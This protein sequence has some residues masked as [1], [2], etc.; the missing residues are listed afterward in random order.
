[1]KTI[2]FSILV[3]NI[4]FS[5]SL[6]AGTGREDYLKDY[7]KKFYTNL[8]ENKPELSY[9]LLADTMKSLMKPEQF[10]SFWG[11]MTAQVG[12]FE[13]F[14]EIDIKPVDDNHL[15][16]INLFFERYELTGRISVN[17]NDKVVG[18]FITPGKSRAE[19]KVPDYSVADNFTEEDIKFGIDGYELDG[20]ITIP[21]NVKNYPVVIL[22]HG[23]GPND[24]DETIGGTKPFRDIAYGLSSNGVA[25]IR[26]NKR[27]KQHP[28]KIAEEIKT[29]GLDA[30]VV[31]DAVEAAK[32]ARVNAQK[33]GINK[34]KIFV[35]GHSLGASM[36][37]KVALRD[38]KI[39][40]IIIMAGYTRK[41]EQLLLDQYEYIFTLDDS[42]SADEMAEISKLK[43]QTLNFLSPDLSADTDPTTLPMGMNGYYARDIRDYNPS[44]TVKKVSCPIFVLQGERDY[45]VKLKDFNGWKKV[46]DGNKKATLKLYPKLN[47]LF[48][49][50]E[51][52]SIPS[53]YSEQNNVAKVIID[54]LNNWILKN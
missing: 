21:K 28:D 46:L 10:N 1:M 38:D 40:G 12:K 30:E 15:V 7:V 17:K 51:S 29:F 9:S 44:E 22:V 36:M 16:I 32:F 35:L 45:Q 34:D 24:M 4:I 33:F 48:I 18:F 23:S 31:D 8:N 47:H 39:A 50:G 49:Y 53:E 19:F 41:F 37:P 25:V 14:G 54:D 13:G 42:I 27:T 20:K 43:V 6:N 5:L 26:Y 11:Q 3:L 2:F 52:K